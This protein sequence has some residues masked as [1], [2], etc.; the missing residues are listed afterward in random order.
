MTDFSSGALA[1]NLGD[2][3]HLLYAVRQMIN[4]L[5]PRNKL[6]LLTLESVA[7]EDV[8]LVGLNKP[9]LAADVTE[10][11]GGTNFRDADQVV[12]TQLKYSFA[13]AAQN[14]TLRRLCKPKNA[15]DFTSSVIGG[16]ADIFSRYS[17]FPNFQST[18]LEF[19]IYTNRPLQPK[20]ARQLDQVVEQIAGKEGRQVSQTLSHLAGDIKNTLDQ[21]KEASS[22]SWIQLGWFLRCWKRDSF[23]QPN[24]NTIERI[25]FGEMQQILDTDTKRYINS[26]LVYAMKCAEAGERNE[27]TVSDVLHQ[28][29]FTPADFFPAPYRPESID[30]FQ[31]TQTQENLNATIRESGGGFVV[32]HGSGGQGKS[33][34]LQYFAQSSENAG[35]VIVYDCWDGGAA[36]EPGFERY[37]L[38]NFLTQVINELDTLYQ[39]NILANR[40]DLLSGDVYQSLVTIGAS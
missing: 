39:T 26:L 6:H 15:S 30:H 18:K 21:L 3:Y 31:L 5:Q 22:L 38:E 19:Q 23:S 7:R 1:S 24:L 29:G 34:E 11:Y 4:M 27:I 37:Q 35:R 9:I 13:H 20:L 16:L 8:P 17:T 2:H 12:I 25:A 32:L 28:L 10:Y 33:T 40:R 14:W 36:R